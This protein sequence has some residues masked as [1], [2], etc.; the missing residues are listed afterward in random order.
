MVLFTASLS[1]A[2]ASVVEQ[3]RSSAILAGLSRE[4]ALD[5]PVQAGQWWFEVAVG[6]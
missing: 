6:I 4:A 2:K 5:F 1:A 3:R